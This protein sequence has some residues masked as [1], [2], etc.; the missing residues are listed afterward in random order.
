VERGRKEMVPDEESFSVPSSCLSLRRQGSFS[1]W[2]RDSGLWRSCRTTQASAW[3]QRLSRASR[4]A[5]SRTVMRRGG[6]LH[7]S[8]NR[9]VAPTRSRLVSR[10]ACSPATRTQ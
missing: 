5:A 10:S 9:F 7:E 1:L 6:A 8:G 3:A 2:R 4:G